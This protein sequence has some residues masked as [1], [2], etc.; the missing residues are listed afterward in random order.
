MKKYFKVIDNFLNPKTFTRLLNGVESNAISWVWNKDTYVDNNGKGDNLWMF[1]Q[2]LF[3]NNPSFVPAFQIIEDLQADIVPFKKVLKLK[4][5]LYPNQGKNILHKEHKDINTGEEIDKKVITSIF[6]FHDCNGGTI[7]NING[8][9]ENVPS[10]ANRL[11]LFD[12]SYHYGYTQNDLPRRIVL[13]IN[14]IK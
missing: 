12:N 7:I 1:N 2:V 8:K 6:N 3:N 14:V 11:I 10:K 4:L 9:E 5:N 13:N